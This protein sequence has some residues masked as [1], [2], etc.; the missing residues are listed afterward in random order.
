MMRAKR[1]LN[2]YQQVGLHT[3]ISEASPHRLVQM[4]FDGALSRIF[5]AKGAMQRKEIMVKGDTIG[6]V[7]AIVDSLRASLN[8]EEGGELAENLWS[9]Y[10][11]IARRLVL[12][13]SRNSIEMLDECASLLSQVKEAWD[14]IPS[15]Y[16]YASK[17]EL[18]RS[19]VAAQ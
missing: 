12:A 17:A 10:D 18:K 5:K 19:A 16:H 8:L 2:Q 11:Y 13:N 6:Q 3:Q 15:K 4:M 14:Q 1:G 9:L 7:I